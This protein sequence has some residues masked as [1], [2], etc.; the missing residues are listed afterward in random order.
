[1]R[2]EVT[3]RRPGARKGLL[4]EYKPV[5]SW[6]IA[7]SG[8]A[9]Y[10]VRELPEEEGHAIWYGYD[11]PELL[12]E[13]KRLGV[14]ALE[15]EEPGDLAVRIEKLLLE[16]ELGLRAGRVVPDVPDELELARQRRRGHPV[17]GAS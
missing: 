10:F 12:G 9:W 4:V 15:G 13:M 16:T 8:G 17:Q 2:G 11:L 3:Y 14:E 7:P 5:E 6:L 1:M